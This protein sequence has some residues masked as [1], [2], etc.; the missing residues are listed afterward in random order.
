M[1]GR[2]A[3][4]FEYPK[5]G[6]PKRMG[7]LSLLKEIDKLCGCDFEDDCLMPDVL[8]DEN[9]LM[10]GQPVGG[11]IEAEPI[12]ESFTAQTGKQGFYLTYCTTSGS[13]AY[14][15]WQAGRRLRTLEYNTSNP[16]DQIHAD[17]VWRLVEGEPETWERS[18][19]FREDRL[20]AALSSEPDYDPADPDCCPVARQKLEAYWRSGVIAKGEQRPW[21]N[22]H[23]A[24]WEIMRCY[25]LPDCCYYTEEYPYR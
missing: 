17:N 22:P 18:V 9:W 10:V 6:S 14:C 20:L 1:G 12:L 4:W 2:S 25:H 5:F 23:R 24:W 7:F 13:F 21:P 11:A 8:S 3:F 16:H 15:H 19:F